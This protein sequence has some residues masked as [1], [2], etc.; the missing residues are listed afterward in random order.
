MTFLFL[1]FSFWKSLKKLKKLELSPQNFRYGVLHLL[2]SVYCTLAIIMFR[3]GQNFLSHLAWSKIWLI[4]GGLVTNELWSF[5]MKFCQ[6]NL[7]WLAVL[8]FSVFLSRP[9]AP[10]QPKSSWNRPAACSL[11]TSAD[12]DRNCTV[13]FCPALF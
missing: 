8:K 2:H 7:K 10:F 9:L 12:I 6:K 11:L 13:T 1:F 4:L 3:R 5:F